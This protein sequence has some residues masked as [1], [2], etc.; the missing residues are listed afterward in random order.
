MIP[1]YSHELARGNPPCRCVQSTRDT[2]PCFDGPRTLGARVSRVG[3]R[4]L[5]GGSKGARHY[6]QRLLQCFQVLARETSALPGP[7][8][9]WPTTRVAGDVKFV[10]AATGPIRTLL[11]FSPPR[12]RNQTF[13]LY[14]AETRHGIPP[15]PSCLIFVTGTGL[16]Y[17]ASH[18]SRS[19]KLGKPLAPSTRVLYRSRKIE[20]VRS[21]TEEIRFRP[22][23]SALDGFRLASRIPVFVP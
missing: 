20:S 23:H 16:N 13:W 3:A 6:I 22:V 19:V 11:S 10:V 4:S 18:K 5:P 15:P 21:G 2:G 14:A 7:A 9:L 12:L 8:S 1:K 17:H